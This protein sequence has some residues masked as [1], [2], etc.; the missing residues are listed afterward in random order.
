LELTGP[1]RPIAPQGGQWQSPAWTGA[2]A[3][4]DHACDAGPRL[5]SEHQPQHRDA[6]VTP[7]LAASALDSLPDQPGVM[8]R[9]ASPALATLGK[10]RRGNEDQ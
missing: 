7:R 9:G 10:C 6:P 8:V 3:A 1:A 5:A 4:C 2:A